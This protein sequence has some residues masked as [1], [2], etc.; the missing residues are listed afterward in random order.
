[1][2]PACHAPYLKIL[3]EIISLFTPFCAEITLLPKSDIKFV[4]SRG[5]KVHRRFDSLFRHI[6]LMPVAVL[7]K[8]DDRKCRVIRQTQGVAEVEPYVMVG[9]RFLDSKTLFIVRKL[10]Q[11]FINR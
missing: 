5:S 3:S 11:V 8:P 7:F 1:M 9:R 10:F 4:K 6:N 2:F